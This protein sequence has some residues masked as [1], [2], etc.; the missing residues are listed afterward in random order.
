LPPPDR[1]A[2]LAAAEKSLQAAGADVVIE[3]VAQLIAA[4]RSAAQCR[5]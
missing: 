4:L 1:A 5:V 2:R 3:T